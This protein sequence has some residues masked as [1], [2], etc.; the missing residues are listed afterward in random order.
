MICS[1]VPGSPFDASARCRGRRTRRRPCSGRR[2]RSSRGARRAASTASGSAR[3]RRASTAVQ[4]A[5]R[6]LVHELPGLAAV[7]RAPEAEVRR[8][9]DQR[10]GAAA[11]DVRDAADG[12]AGGR[13]DRVR[14]A[15]LDR[16]RADRAVVERVAAERAEPACCRRSST[17]RRRR[18]PRSRCRR[19]W[20]RRCRPRASG[21]ACRWGRAR[22]TPVLLCSKPFETY[23]QSGDGV[24]RVVRPPDAAVRVRDPERALPVRAAVRID[25]DVGDAAAEVGRAG[26]VDGAVAVL[27]A[28]P[29]GVRR[30]ERL[31]SLLPPVARPFTFFQSA[32]A[33]WRAAA[34]TESPGAA[35]LTNSSSAPRS[36]SWRV[37]VPCGTKVAFAASFAASAGASS[38]V[39]KAVPAAVVPPPPL[40]SPPTA[41]A[42]S[43]STSTP[44]TAIRR[45]MRRCRI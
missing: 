18:P 8:A 20:A 21:P 40:N 43:R 29:L 13:E 1:H 32:S 38:S 27:V 24:E 14:V 34:G 31:Q 4:S 37:R 23:C 30:P 10:V 16:D 15:R 5:V 12:A 6:A 2:D 44:T 11:A 45:R 33:C 28:K 3:R 9:R 26:V 7:L 39:S 35:C 25:R 36:P 17:C 22:S 42:A 19:R 41:T